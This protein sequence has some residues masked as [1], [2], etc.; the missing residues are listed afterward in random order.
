[1]PTYQIIDL[2]F[3]TSDADNPDLRFTGGDFSF[4]FTDWREQPVRFI[5][6]EVCTFS[7]VDEGAISDIR[8]DVT[9]EVFDSELMQKCYSSSIISPRD[10]Y[11]HFKL[12]F[13]AIGVLDV[14]CKKISLA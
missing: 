3:S 1:M 10:G 11:R 5:A 7:W 8:D 9:Y 14:V 4:S 2:G 13:N 12:C 6:A